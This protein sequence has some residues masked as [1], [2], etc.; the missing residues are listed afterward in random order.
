[1]VVVNMSISSGVV[2]LV[3]DVVVVLLGCCSGAARV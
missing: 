1:M 2:L 3:M